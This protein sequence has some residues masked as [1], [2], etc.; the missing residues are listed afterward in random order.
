M[1]K[2]VD[3][4]SVESGD[5]AKVVLELMLEAVGV[6]AVKDNKLNGVG[7]TF[8]STYASIDKKIV[9]VTIVSESIKK[10]K[11]TRKRNVKKTRFGRTLKQQKKEEKFKITTIIHCIKYLHRCM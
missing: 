3:G 5:E 9:K 2:T 4:V 1:G 10:K 6:E 7:I 8:A 11:S